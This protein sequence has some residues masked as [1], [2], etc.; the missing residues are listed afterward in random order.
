[1]GSEDVYKRQTLQF[2]NQMGLES[3]ITRAEQLHESCGERF[4]VPRLL[5]QMAKDQV[6]FEDK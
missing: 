2:I 6:I 4:K 3:F 5:K 1:M